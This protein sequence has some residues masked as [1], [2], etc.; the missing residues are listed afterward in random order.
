[1]K[2]RL[3]Q[4][5][6]PETQIP[7]LRKRHRFPFSP[8]PSPIDEDVT[9]DNIINT[10]DL[11]EGIYTTARSLKKHSPRKSFRSLLKSRSQNRLAVSAP[12][13]V[14]KD[15]R[16]TILSTIPPELVHLPEPVP[17][18]VTESQLV[19]Q[20]PTNQAQIPQR[21]IQQKTRRTFPVLIEPAFL[22]PIQILPVEVTISP[23]TQFDRAA[24]QS[25]QVIASRLEDS[26]RSLSRARGRPNT[27]VAQDQLVRAEPILEPE[28]FSKGRSSF[29]SIPLDNVADHEKQRIT[30]HKVRNQLK[31]YLPEAENE[32][33]AIEKLRAKIERIQN[34]NRARVRG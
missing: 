17:E 25:S 30:A 7:L 8:T 14:K 33:D 13:I 23:F 3:L 9:E 1:V 28:R 11:E 34:R 12:K 15:K 24:S 20:I 10:D 27:I 19:K 5:K 21:V 22:E 6:K 16:P 4:Q 29:V 31:D 2:L 32:G 26:V 18:L